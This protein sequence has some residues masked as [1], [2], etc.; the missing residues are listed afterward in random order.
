MLTI[1]QIAWLLRNTAGEASLMISNGLAAGHV[2]PESRLTYMKFARRH[3]DRMERAGDGGS[4]MQLPPALSTAMA[5]TKTAYFDP[6]Y[7]ALRDRL[8][9][10]LVA[11]EKPEMTANQWSPITVGR[12]AARGHRRRTRAG[13]RQGP[14]RGAAFRGPALA[15]RCSSCCWPSA[16][17]L[18]FGAMM[19]VTRRVIR[20]LHTMRDAMLKV[21]AGDLTVDTGYAERRDEIGA[22]AGA[23][24]TFKQQAAD[25]LRIEAQERERN[26]GAAARQQAIEAYVGEFESHGAPDAAAA[27]RRLQPDADD[28]VGPVGGLPPDQRARPGRREGLRRGLDERRERRFGVARN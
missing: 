23:L 14:H 10:A 28:L 7:L 18:T 3:R 15:G 9:N 4:G 13:R 11:G 26:A 20:P 27:G 5:A 25:K 8:L 22:L 2:A 12:M 6:E 19:A 17:A 21:A 16:L 1:K 24:E